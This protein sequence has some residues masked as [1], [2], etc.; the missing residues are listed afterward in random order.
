VVG[1]GKMFVLFAVEFGVAVQSMYRAKDL[2]QFNV[3]RKEN[4]VFEKII[5]F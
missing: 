5:I 4:V 3:F 1:D 2:G